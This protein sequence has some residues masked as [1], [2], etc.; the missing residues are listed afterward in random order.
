MD[1][2]TAT[3]LASVVAGLFGGRR[4]R[5]SPT[6]QLQLRQAQWLEQF[7]GGVPG[8]S[9]QEQAALAQA[10]GSLGQSQ[11]QQREAL[12]AAQ[13]NFAQGNTGDMMTNIG[14]HQTGQM[15]SLDI[16]H[17]INSLNARQQARLD[18]AAVAQGVGPREQEQSQVGE[19]LSG[20]AYQVGQQRALRRR[21]PAG[22]QAQG[23]GTETETAVGTGELTIPGAGAGGSWVPPGIR[24]P[25]Y[26][27]AGESLLS[28]MDIPVPGLGGSLAGAAPSA[29]GQLIGGVRG[30]PGIAGGFPQGGGGAPYDINRF[31]THPRPLPGG[32]SAG[33]QYN[34][35]RFTAPSPLP[36]GMGRKRRRTA[37]R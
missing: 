25:Q 1:P 19:A 36:A 11:Q 6:Q 15:M 33:T 32:M 2:M 7:A 21:R 29:L 18:A 28:G 17:L 12:Y 31:L 14:L 27:G 24:A 9:P 3:A 22:V 37:R 30:T 34:L 5:Y 23:Q 26:P 8:S 10:R 35:G 16:A 13:P 4:Q 20:L